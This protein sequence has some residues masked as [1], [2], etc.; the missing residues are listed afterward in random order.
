MGNKLKVKFKADKAI[1][2]LRIG[3]A[4]VAIA[5]LTAL[6]FAPK[7]SQPKQP[8]PLEG[9]LTIYHAGSLAAPFADAA[10][11]FNNVYPGVKIERAALGSRSAI[12]QITELGKRADI[13]ASSD[14]TLITEMM[15]PQFADW[16]IIFAYNRMV[17][18]YTNQSKFK[19]EIDKMNWFEILV[20]DGVRYGHSD[21]NQD[22]CGYRTLML[23]QLAEKYY[24]SA[25]LYQS[26]NIANTR[27]KVIRPKEVDLIPLLKSGDLDYAFGYFSLAKQHGLKYVELPVEIDLSEFKLKDFYATARVKIVGNEPGTTTV[28]KGGPV[29][30]GL[31][32]PQNAPRPDLA[33]V[34]LKFLFS[35]DGQLILEKN[36]QM[37]AIPP[38][39]NDKNKL[40]AE[41]KELCTVAD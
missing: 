11:T 13:L 27:K 15:F 5:I 19:D 22:P 7:C 2:F 28:I 38:I 36:Y 16:Y 8:R 10:K 41:L 37:A 39:T 24:N 29:A 34:F 9:N 14:Y 40:P 20:R 25:G 12:R 3:L 1:T 31:T 18:C 4:F 35:K 17:I 21:P 33:V 6:V 30:Y 32:I 26:L 23:W